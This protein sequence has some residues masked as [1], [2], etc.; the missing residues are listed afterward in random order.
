M[1]AENGTVVKQMIQREVTFLI[2]IPQA[3]IYVKPCIQ[4]LTS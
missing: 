4:N 3:S 2:V 1:L